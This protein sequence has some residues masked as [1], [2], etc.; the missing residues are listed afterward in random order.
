MSLMFHFAVIMNEFY[1][2]SMHG[3]NTLSSCI[4]MLKTTTARPGGMVMFPIAGLRSSL[5]GFGPPK[6]YEPEKK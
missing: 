5:A 2:L 4:M 1:I 3:E 6:I